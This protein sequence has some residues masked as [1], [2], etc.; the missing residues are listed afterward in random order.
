[1]YWQ[2][3]MLLNSVQLDLSILLKNLILAGAES[4]ELTFGTT[5]S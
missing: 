1:M 3:G 5:E 2:Y 4:F